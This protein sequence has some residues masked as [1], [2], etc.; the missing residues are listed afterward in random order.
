MISE[1]LERGESG[2]TYRVAS[3]IPFEPPGEMTR[4]KLSERRRGDGESAYRLE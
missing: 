1:E 2:E 4:G 3:P